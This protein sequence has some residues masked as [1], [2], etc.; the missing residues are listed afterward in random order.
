MILNRVG[1][2]RHEEICRAALDESGISVLG[3]IP[4]WTGWRPP[5]AISG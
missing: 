4:R 2:P 3:V 1:S 5:P